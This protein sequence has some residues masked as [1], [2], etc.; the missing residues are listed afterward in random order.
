MKK[1]TVKIILSILLILGILIYLGYKIIM[2]IYYN[3]LTSKELSDG[4]KSYDTIKI[5][6]EISVTHKD[7]ADNNYFVYKNFKI[8]NDFENFE[9]VH[10]YDGGVSY[11][12]YDDNHDSKAGIRVGISEPFVNKFNSNA[13]RDSYD[14][15]FSDEDNI[16]FLE[17]YDINSDLKLI[18]F[19]KEK[20]T[21]KSNIFTSVKQMKENLTIS[22]LLNYFPSNITLI[23]GEYIGYI[24]NSNNAKE[25]CLYKDSNLYY[26][27]FL[28]TDYFTDDYIQDILSTVV[29]E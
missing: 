17:K 13:S 18:E 16:A 25:A 21:L 14:D 4:S 7:V 22:Y 6:G 27:T 2:V 9:M 5:A 28:G 29:I 12:L 24:N 3:D 1:K 8:R 26:I 23:N 20:K 19:L 15:F 11:M 10:E